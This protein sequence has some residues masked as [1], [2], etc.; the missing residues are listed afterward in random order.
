MKRNASDSILLGWMNLQ[1]MIQN[2]KNK[3]KV[4][5][6]KMNIAY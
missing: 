6:R 1:P 5:K 4:R 2:E 3:Q